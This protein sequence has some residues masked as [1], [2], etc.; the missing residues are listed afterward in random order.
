MIKLGGRKVE[1]SIIFVDIRDFTG[2]ARKK[3]PER[4][5]K[6]LN[7]TFSKINS[8]IINNKGTLDKYLGDGI[9]A[10]FGAPLPDNDHIARCFKAARQIQQL[11][12]EG[13]FPF[14]LGIGIDTGSVIVGNIGS[15]KMMD[16]TIVGNSV[17]K[18]ARF[19]DIAR[20]D[21][22]VLRDNYWS[23]LSSNVQDNL[24]DALHIKEESIKID[25]KNEEIIRLREGEAE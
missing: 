19:V 14:K 3:K 12:E 10:F 5:V 16:Y 2:F 13:E 17:N 11:S 8:V 25:Q 22:I 6:S 21:E 18:A 20:G 23:Q 7:D 15:E 4:V 24:E 1:V 9:I